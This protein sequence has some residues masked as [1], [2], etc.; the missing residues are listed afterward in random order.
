MVENGTGGR[1]N[2]HNDIYGKTGT[3]QNYQDAWFIGFDNKNII[4][5]WIG[6]DDNSSTNQ[7]T[8]GSLPAQIFAE[9]IRS[10]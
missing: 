8:G 7:I 4:G 1:A 10:L 9:I 2:V 6:N 3:T 5:I